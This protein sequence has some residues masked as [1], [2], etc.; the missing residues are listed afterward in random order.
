MKN[1]MLLRKAA[2]LFLLTAAA[3]ITR[4]DSGPQHQ[5]AQA[6]PIQLG[7][8]GGNINDHS[9]LY[10]CSGTLGGLVQDANGVQY[11]LSNNHVLAEANQ[12]Q[13]GDP[14]NQPGMVDQNCGQA[15]VVANLTRFVTI[16]FAKGKNLPLNEVDCAI[17][18]VA[19][20]TLPDGSTGPL[21][22]IDGA[23]LDIGT[24]SANTVPAAVGQPVQKSGRT[25]GQT[26]GTVAATDGVVDVGYSSTCGGAAT[27]KARFVN[28][29]LITPGTFSAGGDSG[30]VIFET[31]ST[32]RA[33]GLLFAGSSSSTIANPIGSVLS[34]LGVTMVGGSTPPPSVGTIAGKVTDATTTSPISGAAVS[35]DSG[36]PATTGS[37]GS[38]SFTSVPTGT[39]TVTATATGYASANKQA[40]VKSGASTTVDF[41]LQPVA[42]GSQAIVD[43]VKYA[44]Q[45]GKNKDK[46]LVITISVV[47]DLGAPVASA[48]V[49][50]AVTFN[51]SPLG[52]GTGALTGSSGEA[53]YT[54]RNAANG[55][56]ATT[57]T[58]V[59]KDGLS[60][61]G[62]FPPNSFTKGG[63]GSQDFCRTGTSSLAAAGGATAGK[64]ALAHARAV[65]A[66][67]SDALLGIEDVVGHGLSRNEKGEPI[68]EIYLTK[69]NTNAR[70]RIPASLEDVPVR[71]VVTGPFM[72]Y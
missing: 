24:V 2:T 64:A 7:T 17:A 62:S 63:A 59:S 65:K 33:V 26:F 56:Y 20:G 9:S 12:G 23:I 69:E 71:V 61:D 52:S 19:T 6:R 50:I 11:I 48:Q 28:Q 14:V 4:A 37:D 51:G 46:D 27:Q 32:P 58:A 34:A 15:G 45:G 42:G 53:S 18:K 67:H 29:I 57:V 25:T 1:R 68:I 70:A 21:V 5:A 31:G 16:Q 54:V 66:R 30:S 8:S 3:T 38:Y 13:S 43:C 44:T 10:C 49:D 47:D 41:A 60:F 40:D 39:H 72:A 36:E 35:V 22:R 55:T